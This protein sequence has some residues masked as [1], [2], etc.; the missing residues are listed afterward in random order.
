MTEL[1][2]SKMSRVFF[3]VGKH[4][5]FSL[6]DRKSIFL[7]FRVIGGPVPNLVDQINQVILRLFSFPLVYANFSKLI[8]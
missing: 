8:N 1:H 3:V 6:L 5:R 7:S 2:F 4:W